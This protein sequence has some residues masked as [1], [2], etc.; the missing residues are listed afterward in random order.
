MNPSDTRPI[1][2]LNAA[3][4]LLFVLLW[5]SSFLAVRVGL[6]HMSP[7]L[8]VALRM[9]LAALILS[10][11]ML[12][13]RRSWSLPW[14]TWL[15]CAVA[16]VLLHAILLMTAQSAMVHTEAA[17]IA[18]IQTLNPLLTAFL[19]WP[20]L[21]EKL[22]APQILG[23]ALGFAGVLL[24]LGLKAM[25]SRAELPG[26]LATA[27][28][29][30]A[31]CAGTLYYGRF[32]RGVPALPGATIQM[33][34]CAVVCLGATWLLETVWTD[35]DPAAFASIAWN[36]VGISLGGMALYFVMLTHGT[37]ARATANF[38]LV[39]GVTSIMTWVFLGESLT[40]L[41]ILGL[42]TA[43]AGCWLVGRRG[44]GTAKPALIPPE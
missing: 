20:L 4:P 7:L 21:G 41:T 10:A 42:V 27:A 12:I 33:L 13:L 22:R 29:V 3:A 35:W 38:Y 16:G 28:G 5:S 44:P 6:R 39:P 30:C 19:A 31:L 25:H 24:I 43:S 11:V 34:A 23:L 37:A 26:L 1:D 17:P 36:T 9:V 8:F 14:K 40:P 2:R 15:H 32:C 18:L